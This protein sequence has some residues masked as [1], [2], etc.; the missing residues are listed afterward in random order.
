L[1]LKILNKKCKT[2]KINLI[3]LIKIGD[4]RWSNLVNNQTY[5]KIF[6]HKNIKPNL[7]TQIEFLTKFKNLYLNIFKQ[8]EDFS[9]VFI[10]YLTNNF[11]KFWHKQKIQKQYKGTLINVLKQLHNYILLRCNMFQLWFQLK[12]KEYNL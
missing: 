10:F 8:K 9:H 6:N 12:N 11:Y 7:T 4:Q 1:L 5:G 2:K 3:G